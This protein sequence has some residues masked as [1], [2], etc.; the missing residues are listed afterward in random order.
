MKILAIDTSAIVASCALCED[1]VPVA[2]Y[3]QKAGL[4]HSQTMLPMVKNL[5][6]NTN[7]SI[8]DIDML[9]VS[10]GPGSFTGIRIGVATIKGLAFGKGKICVGVSTLEA[11][12]KTISSFA[13]DAIICPV[14]DARRNQLYNA[15]FE[16]HG[17]T[18]LR[19]TEDRL[20]DATE[21]SKELD[22]M[23]KPVYFVGDG[24]DLITKMN[25]PFQRPTPPAYRWQNAYGVAKAA[26]DLYNKAE[27]KTVFTDTLLRPEYLR[28]PQAEREAAEREKANKT[29]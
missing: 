29:N 1:D 4:N 17:D 7:V 6:D 9:A 26:L 20:I 11:M 15:I 10:A 12:A 28:A 3:S 19:L 22:A 13:K 5:M 27:D 21:L 8:D 16:A 14:M 2:V 25:L 18:V 24:Y 23:D